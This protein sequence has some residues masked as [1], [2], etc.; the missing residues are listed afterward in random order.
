MDLAP[1][2]RADGGIENRQPTLGRRARGHRRAGAR[3]EPF[4]EPCREARRRLRGLS[5]EAER[6]Q[7]AA[8]LERMCDLLFPVRAELG[9]APVQL[10]AKL[11]VELP[12]GLVARHRRHDG[13]AQ[14]AEGYPVELRE[15]RL[16]PVEPYRLLDRRARAARREPGWP[17]RKPRA[18]LRN[19]PAPALRR[20]RGEL[21]GCRQRRVARRW[22]AARGPSSRSRHLDGLSSARSEA[23]CDAAA[24]PRKSC[25]ERPRAENPCGSCRLIVAWRPERGLASRRSRRRSALSA[26]NRRQHR[27]ASPPEPARRAA[28]GG[29]SR[30]ASTAV[31]PAA[32]V[33]RDAD[34]QPPG[35]LRRAPGCGRLDARPLAAAGDR[36]SRTIAAPRDFAG[37]LGGRRRARGRPPKGEPSLLPAPAWRSRAARSDPRAPPSPSAAERDKIVI[38]SISTSA[39]TRR[40]SPTLAPSVRTLASMTPFGCRAPAA[41][42]V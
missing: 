16:R 36:A 25:A 12:R 5:R 2:R 18:G 21:P 14:V 29:A 17:R 20:R 24:I 32:A 42:Q 35:T 27:G 1:D 30:A 33:V 22:V 28:L 11:A 4:D 7:D 38:P 3:R 39:S 34:R 8:L 19:E 37:G 10:L 13:R 26:A 6:L 41:R 15:R 40:M 23:P 31:R 9:D